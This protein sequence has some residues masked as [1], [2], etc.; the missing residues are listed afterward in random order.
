MNNQIPKWLSFYVYSIHRYTDLDSHQAVVNFQYM[1][2]TQTVC[3]CPVTRNMSF[4]GWWLAIPNSVSWW[5][6]LKPSKCS[7]TINHFLCRHQSTHTYLYAHPNTLFWVHSYI[8]LLLHCRF[9]S[10]LQCYKLLLGLSKSNS[11]SIVAI[12][13][14]VRS[15]WVMR[16]R[17]RF[18]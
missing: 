17:L 12:F 8:V 14:A 10:L 15:M 4:L 6:P 11:L 7:Q 3:A 5:H 13:I 2:A 9:A 18:W 1:P 16:F